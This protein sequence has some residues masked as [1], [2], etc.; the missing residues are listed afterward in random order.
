MRKLQ[1]LLATSIT[2][3]MTTSCA[4]IFTKKTQEVNFK[5][6]PGT[7]II[8]K[9][10]N[11]VVT[12]I[13]SNGFGVGKFSRQ[14]GKKTI[15]A[16]KDGYQSKTYE[17]GVSVQPW[18]FGNIL[19]GGI[20]GIAIDLATGKMMKY[21]DKLID[22]TLIRDPQVKEEIE[23]QIAQPYPAEMVM[24][25]NSGATKMEDT[26]LR[27]YIDSDPR[28]ARIFYRVI[29]NAPNEIKNTNESY[30]TTTP[31]EETRGFSI[32]GLTY[33]NSRN[34]TIEIKVSKRGYEDQVKRYNV[35]QALDQQE[36]SGFF[37]LVEK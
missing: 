36:I 27:W 28:G 37:E 11:R 9:D 12:E 18:F 29:S 32:P 6:V 15:M 26:V 20:P 1:L 3:L 21:R 23:Q 34:V 31:F 30:M 33:E 5:G 8:D 17:M 2:L 19:I 16:T 7:T 35:R 24:R 22:V 13:G 14:L 25:E 4:S 10:K